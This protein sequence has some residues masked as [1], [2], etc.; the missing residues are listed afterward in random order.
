MAIRRLLKAKLLAGLGMVVNL[1]GSSQSVHSVLLPSVPS[2]PV[3]IQQSHHALW[4]SEV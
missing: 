3:P 4:W 1:I 2:L